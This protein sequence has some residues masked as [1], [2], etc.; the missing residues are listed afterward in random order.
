MFFPNFGGLGLI[1]ALLP[2]LPGRLSNGFLSAP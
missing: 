1:L 2:S